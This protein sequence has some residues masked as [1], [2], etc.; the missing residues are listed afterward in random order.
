M[1][2]QHELFRLM[3]LRNSRDG[4]NPIGLIQKKTE[5]KV[6]GTWIFAPAV[7]EN[8]LT[9]VAALTLPD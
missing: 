8:R 4:L 6:A 3:A 2:Y 7:R 1:L 9:T 5:H